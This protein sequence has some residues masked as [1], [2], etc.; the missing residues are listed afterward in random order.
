MPS[1]INELLWRISG[2]SAK[3]LVA[4]IVD[5]YRM[6]ATEA[7]KINQE[8]IRL[9]QLSYLQQFYSERALELWVS[10]SGIKDAKLQC[11]W[12]ENRSYSFINV[13]CGVSIITLKR[14][15]YR[16]AKLRRANF[17]ENLSVS[18]QCWLSEELI[19]KNCSLPHIVILHGPEERHEERLGFVRL[20]LPAPRGNYFLEDIYLPISSVSNVEYSISIPEQPLEDAKPTP[21]RRIQRQKR[22]G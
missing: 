12:T 19:P 10:T 9:Q 2:G 6:A 11:M 17:R 7:K 18:N 21:K 22:V 16:G 1:V 20:V 8:P 3:K 4:L 15:P 5:A 14:L 13:N